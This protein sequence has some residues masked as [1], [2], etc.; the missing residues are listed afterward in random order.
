MQ[1]EITSHF[2]RSYKKLPF[3]IQEKAKKKE[4]IF[5]HDPFDPRL[6]SH[7]LQGQ[8]HEVWAFWLDYRYRIKF[9]FLTKNRVLFLDIGTHNIYQ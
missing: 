4:L 8:E 1:I 7:K 6:K 2:S 3:E 9:I 5:R